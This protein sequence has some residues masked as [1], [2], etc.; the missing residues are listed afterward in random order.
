MIGVE[1]RH[2]FPESLPEL[3]RKSDGI[4]SSLIET[5]ISNLDQYIGRHYGGLDK[6]PLRERQMTVFE[7]MR[8][9]LKDGQT[10]GY[11]KL[12]TGVGKTVLFTKFIEATGLRTL[13]VVPTT[14]LINQT[15]E[16][17]EEFTEG[18]DVGKIYSQT[19]QF[20]KQVTITT[21]DSLIR[22]IKSGK[23]KPKDYELLVLDEAHMSLSQKRQEAVKKFMNAV[24]LG[25]TATPTYSEVRS[26]KNFLNTEIHSMSIREAVEEDLLCSFSVLLAQSDVDLTNVSITSNGDYDPEELEIAINTATRNSA[27]VELYKKMFDGQRTVTYC[28]GVKHAEEVAELFRK[29]GVSATVI[30]GKSK[31]KQEILRKFKDGEIK[32]LCN[33]DILIQGFDEPRASVCLNLRPTLSMVVAEQRGGRVLR[34]N[35]DDPQKHAFIV[36]F[37]DKTENTKKISVSF[38]QV[39]EEAYMV[40]GKVSNGQLETVR[41]KVSAVLDKEIIISGLKVETDAEEV[42]RIVREIEGKKYQPAPENWLNSFDLGDSLGTSRHKALKLV[43]SFRAEYRDWFGY[44]WNKNGRLAE[45]FSPEFVDI[46][47]A[48]MVEVQ[49]APTGW[50]TNWAVGKLIELSPASL[51]KE[52]HKYREGHPEWFGTYLD[53]MGRIQEF[54]SPELINIVRNLM[55]SKQEAPEG[56]KSLQSLVKS[57]GKAIHTIQRR[58]EIYKKEHPDW[59]KIYSGYH[60]QQSEFYSPELVGVILKSFEVTPEVPE[61]WVSRHALSKTLHVSQKAIEEEAIKYLVKHPEWL[62]T[63]FGKAGLVEHY[64]PELVNIISGQFSK[65]SIPKGWIGVGDLARKLSTNYEYVRKIAELHREKH[66]EWF[67]EN[68]IGGR[69]VQTYSPELIKIIEKETRS[70]KKPSDSWRTIN[71]VA[72]EIRWSHTSVE[73]RALAFKDSNPEWLKNRTSRRGSYTYLSPELIEIIKRELPKKDDLL[74]VKDNDFTITLPNLRAHFKGHPMKL[75]A[76]AEILLQEEMKKNA[77]ILAKRVNK[78]GRVVTVVTDKEWFINVM[79]EK[80]KNVQ[81]DFVTLKKGDFPVTAQTLE[82]IFRGNG[83]KLRAMA[84]DIIDEEMARNPGIA[85]KKTNKMGIAV[86]VTDKEWLIREMLERGAN[87]VEKVGSIT[88]SDFPITTTELIHIFVGKDAKLMSVAK[89]VLEELDKEYPGIITKKRNKIGHIIE[90]C[91][92]RDLFIEAMQKKGVKIKDTSIQEVAADDFIVN[93]PILNETFFSGKNFVALANEVLLE[94][95]N[96]KPSWVIKKMQKAGRMVKVLVGDEAKSFFIK[97]MQE[98]GVKPR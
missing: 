44:F 28:V 23:V 16:R 50:M 89:T 68:K 38:A 77:S 54:Y 29:Q 93:Q 52:V 14:I 43:N 97:K 18:L 42:L 27:A 19:K 61:G 92:N 8:N 15:G 22:N 98:R 66:P 63:Y 5:A 59:I 20:G 88:D 76:I 72:K 57:T 7:D 55:A 47:K 71:E 34:K 91:T 74:E 4:S 79:K 53:K 82:L 35:E 24:K 51:R 70:R 39:A 75:L 56:W 95:E 78:K 40:S 6:K 67:G 9:F 11:V 83:S 94:M 60:G 90:T 17:I 86:F 33:A 73:E 64:S 30:S 21:Y 12:P 46:L 10:E 65:L 87:P 81:N 3:E 58:G 31:D 2:S 41:K 80:G 62:K 48:N 13:I 37:I 25:F 32:V 84:Q 96:I 49:D 26:V 1:N 69:N 36:D 45:Y 85:V